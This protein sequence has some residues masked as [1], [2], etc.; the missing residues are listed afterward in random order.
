MIFLEKTT[1]KNAGACVL[2]ISEK[3]QQSTS[4]LQ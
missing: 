4:Q 1:I 3:T 2:G